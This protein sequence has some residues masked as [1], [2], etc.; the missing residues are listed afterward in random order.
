MN[1]ILPTQIPLCGK[2]PP[3]LGALGD[4]MRKHQLPFV[5]VMKPGDRS[6]LYGAMQAIGDRL[7][8]MPFFLLHAEDTLR[9]KQHLLEKEPTFVVIVEEPGTKEPG[10]E[11]PDSRIPKDQQAFILERYKPSEAGRPTV[12]A[13]RALLVITDED[14]GDLLKQGA[15][16][17]EFTDLKHFTVPWDP[18]TR[19]IDE[20][21]AVFE[22]GLLAAGKA[23][24]VDLK[25]RVDEDA[26]LRYARMQKILAT[27]LRTAEARGMTMRPHV[28]TAEVLAAARAC[29][30]YLAGKKDLRLDAVAVEAL[31]FHG[32]TEA[33]LR[34]TFGLAPRS[35]RPTRAS[36]PTEP[37]SGA[38]AKLAAG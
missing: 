24:G 12:Y 38:P 20:Y 4:A 8:L 2:R 36:R 3:M 34:A 9:Q 35:V 31:V 1:V 22:Q 10:K 26:L 30:L 19:R 11:R 16:I 14:P 7:G 6:E 25:D 29:V 32:V 18:M 23:Q 13:P 33:A 28:S 37:E 27:H 21:R 15:W 17:K 5:L